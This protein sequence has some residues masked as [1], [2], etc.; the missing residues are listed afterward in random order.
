[1]CKKPLSREK[2]CKHLSET[3]YGAGDDFDQRCNLEV[4][5]ALSIGGSDVVESSIFNKRQAKV[6]SNLII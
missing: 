5:Q 2:S 1:M 4:F 3:F 6:Y